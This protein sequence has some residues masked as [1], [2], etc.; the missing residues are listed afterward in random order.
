[1]QPYYQIIIADDD[2]TLAALF[3]RLILRCYPTSVVRTFANGQDALDNYDQTGADLLLINHGMPRMDG[4]TLI[5]IVRARGDPV[6]VIG[7]SG[8]PEVRDA[9]I[10]AGATAFLSGTEF[11]D[12]LGALLGQLL[13]RPAA[14]PI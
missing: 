6:P 8:D 1:M 7:T 13:P 9:Y 3:A 11:L 4:P 5:R 12:G 10:A 2:T 14:Q